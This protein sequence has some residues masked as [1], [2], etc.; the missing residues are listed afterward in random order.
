[1]ETK[2]IQ[3]VKDSDKPDKSGKYYKVVYWTDGT[4]NNLF[5]S[6]DAEKIA[7]A[8]EN[9]GYPVEVEL[10]QDGLFTN[11]KRIEPIQDAAKVSASPV[12]PQ[13]P[14]NS[15]QSVVGASKD[16][17]ICYS[18]GKDVVVAL[19]AKGV[20]DYSHDLSQEIAKIGDDLY[21]RLTIPKDSQFPP[22]DTS[23]I[24]I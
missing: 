13:T 17:S 22:V 21:A 1:M 10:E 15:S 6:Y 18:Y 2:V 23:D 16:K 14:Q 4:K 7:C 20:L 3:D 12:P 8:I 24:P 9:K 11:V 19:I 5:P